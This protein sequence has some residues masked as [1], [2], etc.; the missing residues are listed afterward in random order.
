MASGGRG[1]APRRVIGASSADRT[2]APG[3]T[4]DE[5]LGVYT[6]R[7]NVFNMFLVTGSACRA[8]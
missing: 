7:N 4:G 8:T 3:P 2:G 6:V 5:L 1:D